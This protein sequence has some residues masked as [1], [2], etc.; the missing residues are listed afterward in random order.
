MKE[1]PTFTDIL[2]TLAKAKIKFLVAGGIAMNLHGLQR[3]TMDLD[4]IVFLKKENVLKFVKTITKLGFRP[5][6]PVP[7]ESFAD[8]ELR[9]Q[10]I[11]EKTMVVFSFYH[12]KNMMNVIDV[13]VEH[14]RPFEE[15]FKNK[16]TMAIGKNRIHAVGLEDMLYLKNKANRPKDEFDIRFLK[17]ILHKKRD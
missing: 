4:L 5:K 13:F 3:S 10:W 8:E 6:V 1:N 15:M 12:S 16:K 11:Q 9:K 2:T 17:S 7:A 14:P